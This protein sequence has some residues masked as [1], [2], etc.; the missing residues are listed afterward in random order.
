MVFRC[1]LDGSEFETL[2]WNFRNN[3]EVTVDSFGTIWQSDNDDDGN[4]GVRINY[5][6]EFGNYGYKDEMTG[7]GWNAERTNMETEIPLRHWHLNDPGV[8]PNLLLTGA[9]SPTGISVYEGD[10]LPEKFRGQVIHCDAGPSVTRDVLVKDHG[11][12]YQAEIVNM[13]EGSDPWFR[14]SDVYVAP[15]GSL[16]VADWYDPG[17]GGHGMGDVTRGRLFRVTQ[18][19]AGDRYIVPKFDFSTAAGAITALQNPNNSVRYLAWQALHRMGAAAENGLLELSRSDRAEFRVCALWLL[20]KIPGR[21][22]QTCEVAASDADPRLRSLAIRLARQLPDVEALT[23]AGRLVDDPSPQVRRE[24]AIAV[25]HRHE[26]ASGADL[27]AT[28]GSIRWPGSLVPGST[29]H[30]CRWP[31]GCV[32]GCV[33]DCGR[34]AVEDCRRSRHHLAF[35]GHGD[36][37]SAARIAGGSVHC[38]LTMCRVSCELWIF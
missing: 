33:V 24:C 1:N 4:R 12:G 16:I 11:A 7:A 20:G 9:G 22:Q 28:G 30:R 36:T 18:P 37:R 26:P 13:L 31:M 17:V 14:P 34:P 23:I 15:D 21:G 32:S 29:W 25:R 6:M 2:G 35:A 10:A 27:G 38:R 5:V 8:V 3:W 19:G